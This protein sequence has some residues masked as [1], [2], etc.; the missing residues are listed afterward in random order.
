LTVWQNS[1]ECLT[2]WQNSRECL[3][4]WHNSRECLTVWQIRTS[5]KRSKYG[6][7]GGTGVYMREG[8]TSRVMAAD[9]P[10]GEFYKF[11]SVSPEYFGHSPYTSHGIYSRLPFRHYHDSIY[12]Q[13]HKM[14]VSKYLLQCEL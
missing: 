14:A 7:D 13:E 9:R 3:T 2:V 4:V 1:R 10:Y 12:E 6:G 8:T 5:K 11:Y